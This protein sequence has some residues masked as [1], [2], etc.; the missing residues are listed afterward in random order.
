MKY[1]VLFYIVFFAG[2]ALWTILTAFLSKNANPRLEVIVKSLREVGSQFHRLVGILAVIFL[3]FALVRL[4]KWA[5]F[6]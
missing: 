6:G 1:I 3:L 5:I 2:L 4:I